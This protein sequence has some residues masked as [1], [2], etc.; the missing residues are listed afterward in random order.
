MN[1]IEKAINDLQLLYRLIRWGRFRR[2]IAFAI[3][4]LIRVKDLV[5]DI[6]ETIHRANDV[7]EYTAYPEIAGYTKGLE[8]VKEKFE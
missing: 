7:C 6:D 8:M 3:D 5:D 4:Y 1:K 2:S